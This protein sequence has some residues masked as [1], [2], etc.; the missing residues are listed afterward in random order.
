MPHDGFQVFHISTQFF[1]L[2]NAKI[3]KGED[4]YRMY[5]LEIWPLYIF[6]RLSFNYLS[7]FFAFIASENF[8]FDDAYSAKKS[9]SE[10][11]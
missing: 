4:L 11:T 1:K 7:G 5:R 9:L 8:S 6:F 2:V 3:Q 10:T